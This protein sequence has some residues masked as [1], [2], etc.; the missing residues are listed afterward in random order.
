MVGF[1]FLD[2]DWIL[3]KDFSL[4]RQETPNTAVNVSSNHTQVL[5]MVLSLPICNVDYCLFQDR[6]QFCQGLPNPA[7][8]A[9][10]YLR[11]TCGGAKLLFSSRLDDLGANQDRR[12]N[13]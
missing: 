1:Q 11:P 13:G 6:W 12:I 2:M 7:I 4:A 8:L 3:E 5:H 10:L 9:P